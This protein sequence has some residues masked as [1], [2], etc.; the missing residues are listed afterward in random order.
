M[1]FL[2][3]LLALISVISPTRTW[4][5]PSQPLTVDIKSAGESKLVLV[6]FTTGKPIDAKAPADVSGDKTVD[7][8]TLYAEVSAPGTY[9]LFVVPKGKQLAEFDG[10][11]LL[12]EVRADHRRGAP[13]EPDVIKVGPLEYAVMS[14]EKGPLTMMFYY[15][16]APITAGSFLDLAR[17]GYFD[18]LT[19]HRIMPGF[20]LQGGDPKG[21]GT[22]GPGYN[23]QAEFNDRPHLEGVLSMARQGDPNERAGAMPRPE[24]ANSAGSQFFICLDY[25]TTRQLDHKYTAFGR[26]VDGMKAAKEIAAVPLADPEA[27]KPATP[28]VIPKVEVK[29]VTAAEDPYA[30]FLHLKEPAAPAATPK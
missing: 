1:H 23:V 25:N 28:H 2:A 29:P 19:F 20:V 16:V 13:A 26:V 24:F 27:G 17:T 8:K 4:Y 12:I 9:V 15:D 10:T 22:G 11:P 18:G 30:E 5:A 14:T 6:D 21:D 7:L 3:P